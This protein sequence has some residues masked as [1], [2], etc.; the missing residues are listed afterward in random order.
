M[1][2]NRQLPDTH[3]C[4]NMA[5]CARC[6]C[7]VVHVVLCAQSISGG[8]AHAAPSAACSIG[9]LYSIQHM[10]SSTSVDCKSSGTLGCWRPALLSTSGVLQTTLLK[11]QFSCGARQ[12]STGAHWAAH[13]T[14]D[15]AL[16]P[17][18][19]LGKEHHAVVYRC[20][21]LL[22][23]VD[24]LRMSVHRMEKLQAWLAYQPSASAHM[25]VTG[26]VTRCRLFAVLYAC[27]SVFCC[28]PAQQQLP[29]LR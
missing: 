14:Q 13:S 29:S 5:A 18:G 20:P 24:K 12:H 1:H 9:T 2:C 21:A 28:M 16:S 22:N 11:Q 27:I 7:C 4:R 10:H 25:F 23:V 3:R 26:W 6:M 15:A 8:T 19:E 17:R